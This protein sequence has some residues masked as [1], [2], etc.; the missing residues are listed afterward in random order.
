M[1]GKKPCVVD[2]LKRFLHAFVEI[3]LIWEQC[4]S[5]WL[6]PLCGP[7]VCSCSAA[8]PRGRTARL[9]RQL[10]QSSW[11]A[12]LSEPSQLSSGSW[13]SWW[14][15][16]PSS[17]MWKQLQLFLAV[18]CVPWPKLQVSVLL[19]IPSLT[20][21]P[22]LH[23]LSA[24]PSANPPVRV[25]WLPDPSLAFSACFLLTL[26]LSSFGF[27]G[28]KCDHVFLFKPLTGPNSFFVFSGFGQVSLCICALA[29]PDCSYPACQSAIFSK[30]NG[31]T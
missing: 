17:Q 8:L 12:E 26:Q 5:E 15:A 21:L 13:G 1:W 14:F 6:K 9:C 24:I 22:R 31:R 11:A 23:R 20:A 29:W 30:I 28:P 4:S 7:S 3:C 2:T 19:L 10:Q 16:S 18:H 25:P 27:L